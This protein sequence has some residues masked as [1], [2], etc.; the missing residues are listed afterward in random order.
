MIYIAIWLVFVAI[1]LVFN[2][3]A[4]SRKTHK[5]ST[6]MSKNSGILVSYTDIDGNLQKGVV[7]HT[8]QHPSFEKINK[9]LVRLLNDDLS[10]KKDQ[11]QKNLVALKSKDLLTHIGFCD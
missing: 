2:Y 3:K 4:H 8:D 5:K 11:D 10:L 6:S 1:V 7:Q 9:A